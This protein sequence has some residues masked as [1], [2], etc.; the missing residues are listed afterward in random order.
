MNDSQF[1]Y[2]QKKQRYRT[3]GRILIVI[4]L[5]FIGFGGFSLFNAL[6][7]SPDWDN[8]DSFVSQQMGTFLIG[9]VMLMIGF[10][11]V[12]VGYQ[13]YFVTHM[14]GIAR[15]T[16]VETAPA[17]EIMTEAVATGLSRGFSKEGG[18]PF[19]QGK[20]VVKLKCRQCGYL[21][22]EDA[23]FCSKCGERM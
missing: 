16:A 21:E 11:C 5:I 14:R 13:M 10:I 9:G 18:S 19:S 2:E 6:T 8:F 17:A 4:G 1:D 22:T 20:E 12:V 23:D 3:Y 7:S 15:Y